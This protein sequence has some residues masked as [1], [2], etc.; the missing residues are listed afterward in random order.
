MAGPQILRWQ[1]SS[2]PA[3]RAEQAGML[4]RAFLDEGLAD[5]LRDEA[6]LVL[7]SLLED[8]SELVR[9]T[10]AEHFANSDKVPHYMVHILAEDQQD[11]AAIV[12]ARSPLLTDAEL[13]DC[14]ATS[15]TFGQKAIALRTHVSPAVAAALA[16]IGT[17]EVLIS[18]AGNP[19]AELLDSTLHRMIERHGRHKELREALLA[20]P[21]LSPAIRSFL[22]GAAAVALAADL[23]ENDGLTKEKAE[24]LACDARDRSNLRLA[25]E[26]S[27]EQRAARAFVTYLRKSGQLTAGLLL[28]G[29]FC[30]HKELLELALCELTGWPRARVTS[31]L[32]AAQSAGFATL[33]QRA[34]MPEP[35][36]PAFVAGLQA[37]TDLRLG[38]PV[39]MQLQMPLIHR[40]LEACLS[41]NASHQDPVIASLRHLEAEAACE[42]ARAFHSL[43]IAPPKEGQAMAGLLPLLPGASNEAEVILI[44]KRESAEDLA[45]LADIKIDFEALAAAIAAA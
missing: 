41:K 15:E 42:E 43:L 5:E 40:A 25:I 32:A 18:L 4:A 7:T 20:R 29:L 14:A 30:G 2:S 26:T 12:L 45:V 9:R 10:L 23:I 16:E 27:Y 34:K 38:N 21:N 3:I 35:L 1:W 37:L 39:E 44:G 33:Y 36:L 31:H 11:I 24:I 19:G 28:R 17:V 22:A 6:R 8:P 13:I